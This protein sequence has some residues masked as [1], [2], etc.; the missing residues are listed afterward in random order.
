[1]TVVDAVLLPLVPLMV[2]VYCPGEPEHD[3]VEF[4]DA[5]KVVAL[6]VQVS[7]VLGETV[8]LSFTVP[9]NVRS[10]LTVIV[11]VP[12]DP[13]IVG[14]LVGLAVMVNAVPTTNLIES[15]CDN[16]LPV[17]VTVTLNVPDGAE[18]EHD[19]IEFRDVVVV[20]NAK[21]AGFRTQLRPREGEMLSVRVTVPVKP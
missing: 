15:E 1:M 18:S 16:P 4:P 2:T 21:L 8:S 13:V 9:K 20:L 11:E 7:P 10:Y 17:P 6:R 14:T 12:D 5:V 19:R 3:N